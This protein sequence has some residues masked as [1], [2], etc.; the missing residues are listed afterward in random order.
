MNIAPDTT[1]E[2]L[3]PMFFSLDKLKHQPEPLYRMDS[4]N[5]RYYYRFENEEPVFYTSVTTLIKNTLPTSPFLIKWMVDKGGDAGKEEALLRAA[6]GTFL[7]SQCAELL[8]SGTYNLD[9]LPKK[10]ALFTASEKI[11]A[12]KEWE[13]EL[14][15]DILA[16]AQFI[17]DNDVK[18][19]AIE[20]CLYHPL[21]GYAGA[22]DLVAELTF[23]RKRIMAIIDLKSGRKGFYESHEVQLGAYREMWNIHFPDTPIEMVFNWQPKAW[24][25]KPTYN[26]QNQTNSQNI[27]KLPHLVALS[28]IVADQRED[29]ITFISGQINVLEGLDKNIKEMTFTEIVKNNK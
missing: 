10:L 5:N 17:I 4:V 28:K 6:Y 26:L 11:T 23:N 24:K 9:D 18:P 13:E 1:I 29:T 15:K 8:I 3:N 12:E 25:K 16:F 2:R 21:D 19:L 7:H 22:L 14:K 20:I 27:P